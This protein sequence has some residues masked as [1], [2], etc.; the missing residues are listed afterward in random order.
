MDALHAE[1]NALV[2]ITSESSGRLSAPPMVVPDVY[3]PR[4]AAGKEAV[5]MLALRNPSF[6]P[7]ARDD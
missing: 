2:G 7:K 3:Q 1:L 5:S 4:N 6:A